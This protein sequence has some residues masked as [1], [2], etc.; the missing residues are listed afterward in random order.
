MPRM[1]RRVLARLQR[2]Q[3]DAGQR[4]QR[5]FEITGPH[6]LQVKA[7]Q[8]VDAVRDFL[9][10]EFALGCRDEN[11]VEG[12][13]VVAVVLFLRENWLRRAQRRD[14]GGGER[15]HAKQFGRNELVRIVGLG[16][17][18]SLHGHM[19]L[20]RSK[21]RQKRQPAPSFSDPDTGTGRIGAQWMLLLNHGL[22]SDT[23][24]PPLASVLLVLMVF[25]REHSCPGEQN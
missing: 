17:A 10:V 20:P 3:V 5:G 12:L 11:F 14:N 1:I 9:K 21:F 2:D 15:R 13:V 19:K 22:F 8:H 16:F 7:G 6:L 4:S 18:I 23:R 25:A 24:S